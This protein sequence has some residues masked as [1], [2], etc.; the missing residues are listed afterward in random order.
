MSPGTMKKAFIIISFILIFA[1]CSM[2]GQHLTGVLTGP[3]W[4]WAYTINK[5]GTKLAPPEPKKYTVQFLEAGVLKVK[6][7][8][9][10]KGGTYTLEE[11]GLSINVTYSTRA[12]CETGSFEDQFV[13]DLMAAVTP[14]L[15]DDGLSVGLKDGSGRMQFF[16]E[17][18][19]NGQ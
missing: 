18:R 19:K 15:Q 12:A 10:M 1:S 14:V 7:D 3:V 11:T 2:T 4:E 5:D 16:T 6:A 17:E 13:R 9:N 8:C